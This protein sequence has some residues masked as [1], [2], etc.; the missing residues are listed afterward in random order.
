MRKSR[1]FERLMILSI[2]TILCVTALKI[3]DGNNDSGIVSASGIPWSDCE[4]YYHFDNDPA[5]SESGTYIHDFSGNGHY[6]SVPPGK[7]AGYVTNGK[8]NGAVEFDGTHTSDHRIFIHHGMIDFWNNAGQWSVTMWIKLNNPSTWVSNYNIIGAKGSCTPWIWFGGSSYG[9]RI[10]LANPYYHTAGWAYAPAYSSDSNILDVNQWTHLTITRDGTSISFYKNGAPWGGFN[11]ISTQNRYL[12]IPD[13]Q[14]GACGSSGVRLKGLLDELA[15]FS[16][17]LSPTEVMDI[18]NFNPMDNTPPT[19]FCVAFNGRF[20]II[21]NDGD[22]V[23]VESIYYRCYSSSG[24]S[25]WTQHCINPGRP[26]YCTG[27]YSPDA[28][29]IEHFAIDYANN[30]GSVQNY[31]IPPTIP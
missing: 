14:I 5:Y 19:T 4:V 30:V 26:P 31:V 29:T 25:C 10:Q 13:L 28:Q 27:F 15:F 18:Y 21:G 17:A 1:N 12:G 11:A 2:V 24:W 3:N 9:Q 6:G 20:R 23:G 7:T 22:G 8:Y 16:K